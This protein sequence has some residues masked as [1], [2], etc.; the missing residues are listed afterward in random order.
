MQYKSATPRYRPDARALMNVRWLHFV[1]LSADV[2]SSD[3]CERPG[4]T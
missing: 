1:F 2:V 3:V 4:L